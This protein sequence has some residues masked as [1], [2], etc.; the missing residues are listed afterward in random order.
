MQVFIPLVGRDGAVDHAVDKTADRC[1]RGLEFMADVGN[2]P[3]RQL[4][5]LV[6]IARHVIKGYRQF[7]Y[8]IAVV[9]FRHAHL[10]IACRE[11]FGR[12]R[13]HFERPRHVLGQDER[14]NQR[15]RQRHQQ[16]QDQRLCR[17]AHRTGCGRVLRVDKHHR[18][19][20]PRAVVHHACADRI[21]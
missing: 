8:L 11:R 15:C 16:D 4:F 1:H 21:A 19:K 10:K 12:G 3:A 13:D 20:L 9:I 5:Q 14:D 7:V 18:G 6:K 2:K 17:M